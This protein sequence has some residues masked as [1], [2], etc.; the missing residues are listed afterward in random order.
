VEQLDHH[1]EQ[2][3]QRQPNDRHRLCHE[4]DELLSGQAIAQS[5]TDG[6]RFYLLLAQ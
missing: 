5:L 6:L 4:W 1:S 3:R 2:H